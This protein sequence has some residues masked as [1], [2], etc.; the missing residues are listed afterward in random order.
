MNGCVSVKNDASDYGADA[1]Y[2][3][4]FERANHKGVR[5]QGFHK[6]AFQWIENKIQSDGLPAGSSFV[7]I[8]P[9]QR[10]EKQ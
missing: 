2:L 6:E 8:E 3:S 5:A 10:E 1:Y 7:F 4:L 9:A